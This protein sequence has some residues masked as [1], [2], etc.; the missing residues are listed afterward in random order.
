M[1]RGEHRALPALIGEGP[2]TS[3]VDGP[4]VVHLI[5]AAN[6]LDSPRTFAAALRANPPG[7]SCRL[8]L[9]LKGFASEREAQ[10]YVADFA[11]LEPQTLYFDDAGFDLGVYLATAAHLRRGRYCFLNSHSVPLVEGWLARLDEAL[12]QPRTGMVGATASWASTRSWMAY[13]MGLPSAYRGVLPPAR[14]VRR[15]LLTLRPESAAR[16]RQTA[17]EALRL[18]AMTLRLIVGHERFPAYHLRTN[19]FMMSDATL[20]RLRFGKVVDQLDTLLLESGRNS[21][22]RQVQ[23]LGLRTLV[24]DRAGATFEPEAWDRS[25]TYHQG[26]QEGLLVADNRTQMYELGGREL[27]GTLAH[28]SWGAQGGR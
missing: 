18:R 2:S 25:Q 1:T 12:A 17:R 15:H 22:T 13:S 10:P 23:R 21:F 26:A 20:R 5:R 27:R 14:T 8:V 4:Y 24:V 7:I 9:V 19:A 28:L 6:G 16:G 3:T 11:E